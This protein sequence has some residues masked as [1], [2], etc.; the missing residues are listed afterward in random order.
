MIACVFSGQG[1]QK[2]GMGADLCNASP[3]A[4]AVYAQAFDCLGFDVLALD[5]E[6]LAQTRYAQLAIV[7]MSLAAWAAFNEQVPNL[8]PVA[9]AGFSLGEYSA[10]GASGVLA[11]PDLLTLVQER[12]RLM[13]LATDAVA[14]AM[15]AVMGLDEPL[16]LE[17][18]ARP[19]FAGQVFAVNF[20]SPGQTVIAGFEA[21]AAACAEALTAAGARKIRR[22]NVSGAFHTP[23]MAEAARQLADYARRLA[24]QVPSAPFYSNTGRILGPEINWPD[25]LAEHMCSPVLWTGEVQQMRNDGAEKF[26]EFGPGKV[27][28]GLIR[29]IV[30]D[31]PVLPV[32]D[33]RTLGDAVTALAPVL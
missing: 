4:R 18:V 26:F 25:Y 28:T 7:T 16:L 31:A 33:T 19:Q 29:K 8:P 27:L 12:A 22:L 6:Q 24:F 5:E 23:L 15:Y 14:G 17:V 10:L 1:S 3:A 9:F 20:N 13:Q 2:A 11:L 30:D 32:E 21:P